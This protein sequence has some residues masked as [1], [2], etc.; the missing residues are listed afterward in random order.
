[1]SKIFL[2]FVIV[3]NQLCQFVNCNLK[4]FHF[5]QLILECCKLLLRPKLEVHVDSE[6]ANRKYEKE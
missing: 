3:V 1:M 2:S 6:L 5:S 4:S